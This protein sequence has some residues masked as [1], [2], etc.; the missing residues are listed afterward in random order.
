LNAI[1]SIEDG[2]RGYYAHIIEEITESMEEFDEVSA[3]LEQGGS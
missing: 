2:T 3:N 1:R